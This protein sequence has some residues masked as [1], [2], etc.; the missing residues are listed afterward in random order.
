MRV[1]IQIVAPH[2]HA[3]LE[4]GGTH[5]C[6]LSGRTQPNRAPNEIGHDFSERYGTFRWSGKLTQAARRFKPRLL[7]LSGEMP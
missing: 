4:Y 3:R 5:E 6:T 1:P 2:V 7:P